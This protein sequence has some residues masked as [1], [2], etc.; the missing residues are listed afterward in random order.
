M[1]DPY[2]LRKFPLWRKL[3]FIH[4]IQKPDNG[5]LWLDQLRETIRFLHS[6]KH[7]DITSRQRKQKEKLKQASDQNFQK[8]FRANLLLYR[9]LF[10]KKINYTIT[11]SALLGKT[12]K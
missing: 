11:P 3:S 9:Q 1:T 5:R 7:C 2:F 12:K 6:L 8:I 4:I 10:S